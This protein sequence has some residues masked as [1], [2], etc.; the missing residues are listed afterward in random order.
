MDPL[1]RI[2]GPAAALLKANI[3][4]DIIA[5]APRRGSGGDARSSAGIGAALFFAPWRFDAAGEEI[6]DFVL[7]RPPFR[8]AKFLVAGDNFACGS[9]RESAVLYLKAWGL[10]AV[11][12]PSFGQIFYD[13]CFRNGV[14]PLVFDQATVEALAAEAEGGAA[15]AADVAAGTLTTPGSR[16][17]AFSLPAFRRQLLLTGT[18]EVTLTLREADRIA[19]WQEAA[20]QARPWAYPAA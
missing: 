15:F 20:R 6:P 13:N 2:E 8:E 9:S 17:L 14:L 3:N 11:I 12:A 18:D 4:T 10:R 1:T 7:N 5:P 16:T 19:A